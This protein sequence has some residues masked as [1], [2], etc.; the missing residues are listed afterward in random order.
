MKQIF[1]TGLLL[2]ALSSLFAQSKGDI[3]QVFMVKDANLTDKLTFEIT[4]GNT[5]Q[6][7]CF[8]EP[9]KGKQPID[10]TGVLRVHN[11][12]AFK[13]KQVYDLSIKI[14]NARTK[15]VYQNVA[16]TIKVQ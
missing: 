9:V 10:S 5:Y 6:A 14:R 3:V 11:P 1:L 4:K 8:G 7:F 12:K 2:F 16:L 13:K 15:E